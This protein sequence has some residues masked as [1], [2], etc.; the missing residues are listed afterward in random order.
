MKLL[1]I[2]VFT[3][4]CIFQVVANPRKISKEEYISTWSEEA[5]KQ[6]LAHGI[7]ASITMAQA[8]LESGN[9][10]SE[11]ARKGNNH[12]GIKCHNWK[13]KTMK[14]D[15]DKKNE[16]FRV[17]KTAEESYKDHSLFLKNGKRYAFLFDYKR[18][19]YK[20][21][22]KGLKKAGYATNPKYPNLLIRIIED[23]QL[24]ELDKLEM[25]P[26]LPEP[27]IVKNKVESKKEEK[28]QQL[29]IKTHA[30]GIKYVVAQAGDTYYSIAQ[31]NGLTLNQLYRYNDYAS[32][33]DVL[34]IGDFVF[35]QKKKRMHL[36]KKEKVV[37]NKDMTVEELSQLYG[38]NVKTIKRLNNIAHDEVVF[39][40][41][42][43]VTLR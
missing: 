15:D 18:T 42:D 6:M 26:S 27:Q 28:G 32:T 2:S 11:L 40:Q 36:F 16:C 1:I 5:V 38:I 9:G 23:Y 29:I 19:N 22:A 35:I 24:Y 37:V 8:I 17:Y 34:E 13:G 41:G 31:A 43:K 30:V 25:N 4:A 33:K 3:F 39:H 20:A 12:F 21:W 14:V 10:N 7:P